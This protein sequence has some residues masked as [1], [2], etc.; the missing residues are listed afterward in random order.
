[1]IALVTAAT[2]PGLC[3][4]DQPLLASLADTGIDFTIATWDDAAVPWAAYDDVILRSPWDYTGRPA[5]FLA[6]YE[7]VAQ[8]S[9]VHN[10]LQMVRR[11]QHKK[12]LVDLAEAGV[13]VVPT[14]VVAEQQDAKK[15]ARERGWSLAVLKPAIGLGGRSMTLFRQDSDLDEPPLQ[16]SAT[17][18]CVQPYV[19]SIKTEGEYSVV[20]VGGVVQHALVKR[21]GPTDFRVHDGRGGTHEPYPVTDELAA[22]AADVLAAFGAEHSLYARVDLIRLEDGR[23]ALMELDVTSPCLYTE[24][25]PG[26]AAAFAAA[27]AALG[28]RE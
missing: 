3:E 22:S 28:S 15:V 4:D 27:V 14:V 25:N 16:G 23:L 11:N 5:E 9:R 10:E 24:H 12:Y 2:K 19:P 21:P 13:P 8:Q 7:R 26:L 1:M 18:W 6:W 20:V 17:E